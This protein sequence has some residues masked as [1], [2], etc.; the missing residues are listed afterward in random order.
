MFL[1]VC[2]QDDSGVVRIRVYRQ[3]LRSL[4]ASGSVRIVDSG[5]D[6]HES[7]GQVQCGLDLWEFHRWR[8]VDRNP[9]CFRIT[10]AYH[11]IYQLFPRF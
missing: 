8:A 4:E 6:W 10:S 11:Y 5:A 3:Q 9:T 1:E 7:T 2:V